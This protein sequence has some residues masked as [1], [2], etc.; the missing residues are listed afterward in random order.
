MKAKQA[1]AY[2]AQQFAEIA[3]VT[4][5]ALHYYDRLG[6][7]KP[8]HRASNGY[9]VYSDTDLGRL[10][11][12]V[13]LKLL[14]L[15]LKQIR[16]V[17]DDQST[18]RET[19]HRQSR[20]LLEKQRQLEGAIHAVESAEKSLKSRREPDWKFFRRIL[21]EVQMQNDTNWMMKYYNEG[22]RAKIEKRKALWN[23]EMQAQVTKEWE[24]LF[25]DVEAS[26]GENPASAKAQAL[27]AR[28]RKLVYRFTG[29]DL[30]IQKGLGAMSADSANW[31]KAAQSY[32][33][34][35]DIQA[36]IVNAMKASEK[37]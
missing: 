24:Q 26:L 19:L 21:K 2:Y 1:K 7:L 12:I 6:L 9:R 28:W 17:L 33:V 16:R 31:P 3:G 32:R 11:Q 15:Q 5:R 37:K 10:E 4:V 36:F 30:E 20:M 25:A 27:V 23:P 34:R 29:G 14:G 13:V 18:L 35:P 22:A 8:R